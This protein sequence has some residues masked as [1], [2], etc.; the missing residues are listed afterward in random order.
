MI[1]TRTRQKH[2]KQHIESEQQH[3][4]AIY[5]CCCCAAAAGSCWS[6]APVPLFIMNGNRNGNAIN[7]LASPPGKPSRSLFAMYD[8]LDCFAASAA[9]S[10]FRTACAALAAL[11][12]LEA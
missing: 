7:P 5:N 4:S 11:D 1:M 8:N 9:L 6:V 10:T 12:V 3:E 2:K